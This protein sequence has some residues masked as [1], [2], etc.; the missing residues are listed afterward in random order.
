MRI[1]QLNNSPPSIA[2]TSP[3]TVGCRFCSC[4]S[5]A[6]IIKSLPEGGTTIGDALAGELGVSSNQY[7]SGS[8]RPVI[9][10]QDGPRVKVLQHA[11]ETADVSTL[12]PDHAVTVDPILAKQVEIIRGPSTLLYSAGTVGGLVNV[13]DQKIPTQMPEEGLEGTAGLRYNSGSDEKLASA[14]VSG[15]LG[16]QFALRVE[17]SKRKA[18]DLF[19]AGLFS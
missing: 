8:S 9:R 4:R 7:G 17:G 16:D 6:L 18:N 3:G 12:S 19:C 5:S 2:G 1:L 11:S 13:T 14:G 10:G 15:V